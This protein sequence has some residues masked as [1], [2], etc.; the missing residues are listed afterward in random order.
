MDIRQLHV[1]RIRRRPEK[2]KERKISK[3]IQFTKRQVSQ[4]K[5]TGEGYANSPK[6]TTLSGPSDR[7][8]TFRLRTKEEEKGALK[9]SRRLGGVI[10]GKDELSIEGR[11]KKPD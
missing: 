5:R 8:P 7:Q 9:N 6:K 1:K 10:Q 11:R 4:K 2:K 3:E